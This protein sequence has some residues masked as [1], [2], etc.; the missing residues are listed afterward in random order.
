MTKTNLGLRDL[1][2]CLETKLAQKVVAVEVSE[3]KP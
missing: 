2:G 1:A 3:A